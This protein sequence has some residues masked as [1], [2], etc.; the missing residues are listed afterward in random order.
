MSE[1]RPYLLVFL[2]TLSGLVQGQPEAHHRAMSARDF[3]ASDEIADVTLEGTV[4][5][6][7]LDHVDDGYVFLVLVSDGFYIYA[8]HST[9]NPVETLRQLHPFV[10]RKIRISGTA[11]HVHKRTHNR[12][13]TH[14]QVK[15]RSLADIVAIDTVTDKSFTSPDVDEKPILLQ[16]LHGCGMRKTAGIVLARWQGNRII[17]KKNNNKPILVQFKDGV[18]LPERNAAIEVEGYPETD[19]YR[20]DLTRAVWRTSDNAKCKA[21]SPRQ[22]PLEELFRSYGRYIINAKYYGRLLTVCATLKEFVTGDD[23]RRRLLLQDGDLDLQVDCSDA[24]EVLENIEIG[25]IVS[26]TGICVIESD[27]WRPTAPFPKNNRL[28]LVLRDAADVIVLKGPPWWT[29]LKLAIVISLLIGA[30]ILIFIWNIS[31]RV[32]VERRS[33]E[34]VRAQEKKL[35]SELRVAERTRLAADLHDTISQNLTVI[36]YQVSAAQKTLGNGET[37]TDA[38]LVTAAKM[39]RSCRTDLRRCLWDLRNDV[40]DEPDFATAIRKTVEPVVGEAHVR[41]RFEGRRTHISDSTAHALLNV[42]RELAANA[43]RHGGA[44]EIRIAGEARQ[45]GIRASVSDNGCGFDTTQRPGQ[46]EGHFGLDGI[47]ER[48]ERLEG[49]FLI[50]SA[51]GKGTYARIEIKRSISTAS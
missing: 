36:G 12:T 37:A 25:S 24:P 18:A 48:I 49:V 35:E 32:L 14:R 26:A 8:T 34:V 20:I 40:L 4:C 1:L 38:C 50:D 7:F 23:G 51:P 44:S 15:V 31:L 33:R 30:L 47:I 6:T 5:D 45:D 41:I 16:E 28:F 42:I 3:F 11:L 17:L 39:I 46:G 22:F 21:E 13:V 43:V 27:F 9:T 2:L 10:G 19:L 29:P